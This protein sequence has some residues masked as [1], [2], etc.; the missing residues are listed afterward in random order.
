[1]S[2]NSLSADWAFARTYDSLDLDPIRAILYSAQSDPGCWWNTFRHVPPDDVLHFMTLAYCGP[3]Q[4]TDKW[5]VP[6]L[7]SVVS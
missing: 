4:A 7:L 2:A 6:I 3:H 1:M 5:E